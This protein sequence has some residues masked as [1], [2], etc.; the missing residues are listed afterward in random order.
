MC[1]ACARAPHRHSSAARWNATSVCLCSTALRRPLRG[2]RPKA[3]S[4]VCSWCL[5]R[6][7]A[8][9]ECR[10]RN[11][12]CTT[13]AQWKWRVRH[14]QL[15]SGMA[16]QCV[17]ADWYRLRVGAVCWCSHTAPLE[18]SVSRASR[19]TPG[20]CVA[21]TSR[22][23]DMPLVF[24]RRTGSQGVHRAQCACCAE[25][26]LLWTHFPQWPR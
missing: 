4:C 6:T 13:S 7:S 2:L 9:V 26:R 22:D 8:P 25:I 18:A 17:V 21:L 3:P 20:A 16:C 1:I 19:L 14:S 23:P 15:L 11:L 12:F 24:G 10:Q 5:V